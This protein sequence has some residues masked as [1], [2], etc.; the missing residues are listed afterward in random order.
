LSSDI[1][2]PLQVSKDH[3]NGLYSYKVPIKEP[4]DEKQII[5]F[6]IPKKDDQIW[7]TPPILDVK[8]M[9]VR[10]RI[11]YIERERQ[12]WEEGVFVL[13]NGKLKYLTGLMY[14]HLTYN[15][16]NSQKLFYFDD[17][18]GV[19]Y[20]IDLSEKAVE[21]ESRVWVKPRR[22]KMTTIMC[23]LAQYKLQSDYSNFITIQSDTLDKAQKSYMTPIIDSYVR[24]PLWMREQYYAPNGKK[25][26]KALEL[27]SNV[28]QEFDREWMGGKINIFP[29]LPKAID[30]LE[31]VE[32]I[33]DEY[34]KI[35][36]VLPSEMYEIAKPVTQNHRKRGKIDCLSSSGDSKDA[37][38]ATMD[39]HKLIA[40]S[41]PR[42]KD[43]FGKTSSGGWKYFINAIH[44]QWVPKEF[45]DKFGVVDTARA[46]EWVWS[47]HNKHQKGTKPYIFSLYKLPLKEEHALL[48]SAATKI[49]PEIRMSARISEIE[50]MGRIRP[51]V[52]CS[53]NEKEGKVYKE[54]DEMG[55]WMWALDMHVDVSKGINM[56]NRFK[57]RDGIFYPYNQIEGCIGYDPI[58][59][60]KGQTSTTHL[61]QASAMA[62]KKFDYSGSGFIDMKVAFLLIRPD[63]PRT[64]N[65][66]MIKFCKYT[67]YTCMHERSIPHV[68]E[69]FRDAG[70]LN[71]LMKGEDGIYG[72][73]QS[74]VR[75][76]QD[77]ISLMQSRYS[78]PK[79]EGQRDQVMEHPFEDALRS[80]INFDNTNTTAFDPTMA[81]IYLEC[82]LKQ[83]KET[84][85]TD[86]RDKSVSDLIN[87]I[88]VS[89]THQKIL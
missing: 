3:P 67:G 44:S 83:I 53:L 59:Y 16:Y 6:N 47:Q 50:S 39:W 27:T 28:I 62:H 20:F 68:F 32:V 45:T 40:G 2:I 25:P 30:G 49:F 57:M 58:N 11:A 73:S 69:D 79:E 65:K 36:D 61:S 70:M 10:D 87:E 52:R 63:D 89:R 75:A 26:R 56:T 22:A 41:D 23:S 15:T 86:E 35:E 60:P 9:S 48:S 8:R 34:S 43:E 80:H 84:N 19:F 29:T 21:C 85:Q 33:I 46:E 18:L 37:V 31:A 74:N 1:I 7:T 88:I 42:K 51:Y 64:I 77:G 78:P 82:G 54:P 12:R 5:N 76:R 38:K 13:I 4:S 24:R 14:D 72:I 66:E 17:E 71:F 81:E 55:I